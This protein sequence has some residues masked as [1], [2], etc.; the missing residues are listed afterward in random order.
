MAV[1][2]LDLKKGLAV[3]NHLPL[4]T[5]LKFYLYDKNPRSGT[6]EPNQISQVH[7]P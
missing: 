2:E 1:E 3:G 6:V 7:R 4:L 5:K